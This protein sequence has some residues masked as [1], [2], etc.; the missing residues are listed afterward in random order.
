MALFIGL[1]CLYGDAH[2]QVG[3]TE[4]VRLRETVTIR[5]FASL[6]QL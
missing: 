5:L 2:M 1:E 3:S 4:G 6:A